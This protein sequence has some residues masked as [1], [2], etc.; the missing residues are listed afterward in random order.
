MEMRCQV[1]S[2]AN[3]QCSKRNRYDKGDDLMDMGDMGGFGGMGGGIDPEILFSMM[4]NQPGFGHGG[5]FPG[6]GG[7]HF[8]NGGGQRPRGGFPQN[9]HHFS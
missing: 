1:S 4:G 6:G 2:P 7:F 9:F 8:A 3:K 5:A